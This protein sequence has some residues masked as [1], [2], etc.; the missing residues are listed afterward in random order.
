[1]TSVIS[2]KCEVNSL[3]SVIDSL[4]CISNSQQTLSGSIVLIIT[5]LLRLSNSI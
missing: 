2:L 1:M 5:F 3:E 4:Q